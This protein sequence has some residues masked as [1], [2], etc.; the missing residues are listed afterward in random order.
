MDPKYFES[1]IGTSDGVLIL[2]TDGHEL[3]LSIENPEGL[4]A[5]AYLFPYQVTELIAAL[6]NWQRL[7]VGAP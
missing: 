6:V 2:E 7:F 4:R 1:R 3:H 5:L